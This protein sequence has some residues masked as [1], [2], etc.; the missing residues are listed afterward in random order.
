MEEECAQCPYPTTTTP[1]SK[2][3]VDLPRRC[4]PHSAGGKLSEARPY[5]PDDRPLDSKYAFFKF[6]SA[7]IPELFVKCARGPPPSTPLS[8]K[9]VD[10]SAALPAPVGRKW[11]IKSRPLRTEVRL[12]DSKSA[13][14]FC[15]TGSHPARLLCVKWRWIARGVHILL[16]LRR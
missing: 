1:L 11:M 16:L 5:A 4:Q 7:V 9:N 15:K 10:L 2:T 13:F 8:K 12:L 14:F 6:K 3:Y